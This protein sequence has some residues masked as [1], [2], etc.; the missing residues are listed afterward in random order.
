M[1][2][3]QYH[4]LDLHPARL[5]MRDRPRGMFHFVGRCANRSDSAAIR[6]PRSGSRVEQWSGRRPRSRVPQYVTRMRRGA[7]PDPFVHLQH[8]PELDDSEL[9]EYDTGERGVHGYVTVSCSLVAFP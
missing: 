7:G 1:G 9:D 3:I 8:G 4:Q 6:P 2:N 5:P